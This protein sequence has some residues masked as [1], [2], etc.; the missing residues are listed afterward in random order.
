M[1]VGVIGINHKLADLVLR[2]ELAKACHR[3]FSMGQS[4]EGHHFILLST[5]N[6]TEIYFNS[7]DLVEAH[8]YL[9]A[10]L[11]HE[12][13]DNFD[14][15]LYSYFG[16]D[17]FLHLC[18]VTAGLDSAV[19]VETEIQGQVKV[20][21]ENAVQ[22]GKLPFELHYLFQ[23][24]LRVGKKVRSELIIKPGLPGLEHSIF[25]TG[26]YHFEFP[27]RS[28]VLCVGASDINK[29]VISFLRAKRFENITLCNRTSSHAEDIVKRE[30]I[31]FLDW[32]HMSC[33]HEFDWI[34]F[35]T[36]S[37]GCLITQKHLPEN[38]SRKLIIDLCV[39][40]NVDPI[41]GND[42]RIT[43]LNIDQLNRKLKGRRKKLSESLDKA[44]LM[45]T[46]AAKQKV[47]SFHFKQNRRLIYNVS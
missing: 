19:I 38:I 46:E 1:Q 2:E 39:P 3:L 28:N 45:V 34:I 41:I 22:Y 24:A 27:H 10:L 25:Q 4:H 11:R 42:P 7:Q 23:N 43:L 9:L 30:K 6:R 12:I 33:W 17:C 40:R 32:I 35:G 18:R 44:E 20:A 8:S 5:C 16:Y 37:P 29:K 21:Y 26:L 47:L 14:Q 36:K 13:Q 15:K 31:Q